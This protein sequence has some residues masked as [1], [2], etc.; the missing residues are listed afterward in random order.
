MQERALAQEAAKILYDKKG[1][2]IVALDVTKLT[3]MCDYMI[4]ASGRTYTQV[5]ALADAV[6]DRM[7]EIGVELRR[8]EGM[9]EGRW[10][11]LDFG[12]MFVHV[13]HRDDRAYYSLERLWEDGSNRLPLPFETEKA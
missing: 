7:A 10:I 11:V 6:E 5:K 2:D 13:F 1:Y 9:S 8:S 12:M 4:I 3:P